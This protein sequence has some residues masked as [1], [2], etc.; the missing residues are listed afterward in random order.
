MT[1]VLISMPCEDIDAQKKKRH[2]S[3][4]AETGA[5]QL[6]VREHNTKDYWSSPGAR[7]EA[8]DRFLPELLEGAGPC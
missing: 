6:E 5:M 7:R 3:M 8:Q 4:E 2:V 1:E